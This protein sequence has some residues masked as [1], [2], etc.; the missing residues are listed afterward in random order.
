MPSSIAQTATSPWRYWVTGCTAVVVLGVTE[1]R[2]PSGGQITRPSRFSVK[3]TLQRIEA[4]AAA[5]G[6]P[7]FARFDGVGASVRPPRPTRQLVL[8][9]ARGETP[10]MQSATGSAIDLPLRVQVSERADG[11][12]E[13]TIND[14]DWIATRQGAPSDLVK[15]VSALPGLLDAALQ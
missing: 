12:A 13:V 3:E 10:V 15:K 7:V 4:V 14:A 8:G 11:T 9:S 5:R 1:A 2:T 6:L